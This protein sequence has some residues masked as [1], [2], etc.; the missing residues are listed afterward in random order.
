MFYTNKQCIVGDAVKVKSPIIGHVH[1][2]LCNC[3][4]V[5]IIIKKLKKPNKNTPIHLQDSIWF[6][7][8]K[9]WLV[10]HKTIGYFKLTESWME[11]IND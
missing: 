8:H 11:N 5:V 7:E 3:N 6:D 4:K 1:N 10:W 9:T 2:T